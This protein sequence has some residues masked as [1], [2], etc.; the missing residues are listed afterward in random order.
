MDRGTKRGEREHVESSA[1]ANQLK[2]TFSIP[3]HPKHIYEKSDSLRFSQPL[4]D[5]RVSLNHNWLLD[6]LP[7]RVPPQNPSSDMCFLA[8]ESGGDSHEPSQ[9]RRL[10][11]SPGETIDCVDSRK[12]NAS[13]DTRRLC[14]KAGRL[15]RT[16]GRGETTQRQHTIEGVKHEYVLILTA[17]ATI[18]VR[19]RSRN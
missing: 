17:V 3:S 9:S 14:R 16:S 19:R 4:Q 15:L 6:F 8:N 2:S 12:R 13:I 11:V 5:T 10:L 18:G 7:V 1:C